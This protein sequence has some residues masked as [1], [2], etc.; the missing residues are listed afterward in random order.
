MIQESVDLIYY[1]EEDTIGLANSILDVVIS[2]EVRKIATA[3]LKE[4]KE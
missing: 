4:E 3:S 2:D 1:V